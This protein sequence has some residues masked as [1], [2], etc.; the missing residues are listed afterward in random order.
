MKTLSCLPH[1][2]S[3]PSLISPP[4][5]FW[6]LLIVREGRHSTW[7]PTPPGAPSP[8]APLAFSTLSWGPWWVDTSA[9]PRPHD[10]YMKGG[11]VKG[12]T[13]DTEGG[14]LG[15]TQNNGD[16]AAGAAAGGAGAARNTAVTAGVVQPGGTLAWASMSDI[17]EPAA[18]PCD[19]VGCCY[20]IYCFCCCCCCCCCMVLLLLWCT[21]CTLV[22]FLT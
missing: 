11:N 21:M 5:G 9:A 20:Y 8:P 2:T 12:G 10:G 17:Q 15:S 7:L 1:H 4:P 19:E 18:P 14:A 16:A 13:G 22:S 6:R 3:Y